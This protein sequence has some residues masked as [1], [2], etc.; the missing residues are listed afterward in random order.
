MSASSTKR[1]AESDVVSPVAKKGSG[2]ASQ[3]LFSEDMLR[4]YYG[5]APTETGG[6]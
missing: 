2:T 4:V 6:G 1:K 3:E 5:K